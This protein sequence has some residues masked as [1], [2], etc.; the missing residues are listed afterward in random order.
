MTNHPDLIKSL[1]TARARGEQPS[2]PAADLTDANLTHADLT[3]AYLTGANLTH[4]NLTRT[5]LTRANLTRTNLTRANLTDANLT[6][7]DLWRTNLTDANL[8]HADL[9]RTNLT[10]ADLTGADLT[11]AYLTGADLTGVQGGVLAIPCG[12][13]S[14]AVILVPTPDGWTL[15]V[16]CWTG[17]VTDL[18]TRIATDDDWPEA[19]GNEVPRRRPIL[20]ALCDLADAHIAYNADVVPVLTEKWGAS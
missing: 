2:A 3:G 8:T 4:A 19:T 7:A 14:G 1:R 20:T 13:P 6:H 10:G 12:I 9:W 17:T 11:R 5:N 15:R 16:G 18:R